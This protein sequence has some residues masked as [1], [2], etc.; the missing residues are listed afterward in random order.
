VAVSSDSA[1]QNV[2]L[3]KENTTRLGH[4]FITINLTSEAGSL[5]FLGQS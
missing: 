1:F 3:G 4:I 2:V 5:K